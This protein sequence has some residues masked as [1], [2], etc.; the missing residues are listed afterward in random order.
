[1]GFGGLHDASSVVVGDV[2][3]IEIVVTAGHSSV[4]QEVEHRECRNGQHEF[5]VSSLL[6]N[7]ANLEVEHLLVD[8]TH[9]YPTAGRADR[10]FQGTQRVEVP[11]ARDAGVEDEERES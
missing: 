2:V 6:A 5:P 7:H 1:M 11:R 8:R 10:T 9:E 3:F 4:G